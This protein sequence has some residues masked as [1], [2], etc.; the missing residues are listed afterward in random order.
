M[1]ARG[2]RGVGSRISAVKPAAPSPVQCVMYSVSVPYPLKL[3]VN[4]YV[5]NG[6]SRAGVI[7]SC[8][9]VAQHASA[10]CR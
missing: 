4:F 2:S 3:V 1:T 9:A 10:T 6:R 8:E 5:E 7:L